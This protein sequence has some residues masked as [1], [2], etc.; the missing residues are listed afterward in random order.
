MVD[1]AL[2]WTARLRP[3]PRLIGVWWMQHLLAVLALTVCSVWG[4]GRWG[5]S[6]WWTVLLLP[7]GLVL[8][9]SAR[10]LP[11]SFV[12]RGRLVLRP[13]AAVWHR[14]GE[15]PLRGDGYRWLWCSQWLVGI[16]L[17]LTSG[18]R[19]GLWLT[20]WRTGPRAWRRLQ[21]LMR[22]QHGRSD[23]TRPL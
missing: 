11:E 22:L 1:E 7:A 18:R 16:E 20:S 14:D 8:F 3:D 12:G 21:R 23:R 5:L 2:I 6:M 10:R 19:C 4:V 13:D 15:D 9:W 17:Q